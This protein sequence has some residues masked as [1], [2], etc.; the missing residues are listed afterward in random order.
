MVENCLMNVDRVLIRDYIY[1]ETEFPFI[2]N[3]VAF[4]SVAFFSNEVA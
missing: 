1:Q 3:K 2:S 4:I